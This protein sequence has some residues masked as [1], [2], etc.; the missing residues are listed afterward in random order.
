LEAIDEKALRI[1]LLAD[2]RG[3]LEKLRAMHHSGA[4]GE[5]DGGFAI[6]KEFVEAGR[7]RA[8]DSGIESRKPGKLDLRRPIG[9]RRTEP[10][11]KHAQHEILRKPMME[12]AANRFET[13]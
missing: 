13:E 9:L 3:G 12:D 4:E 7:E 1:E 10:V 5:N 11:R 2:A 6:G 8:A